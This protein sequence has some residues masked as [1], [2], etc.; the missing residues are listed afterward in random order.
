MTRKEEIAVL[1]NFKNALIQSYIVRT[2]FQM[3]EEKELKEK[4]TPVIQGKQKVL[5]LYKKP[6]K[7]A[8]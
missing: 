1:K 5:T 4:F 2:N 6:Y 8:S 3:Q 7:K